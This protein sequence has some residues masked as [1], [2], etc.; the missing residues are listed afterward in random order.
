MRT[1][2]EDEQKVKMEQ[3]VSDNK[4]LLQDDQEDEK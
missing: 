2:Y 3:Y 1:N 4:E